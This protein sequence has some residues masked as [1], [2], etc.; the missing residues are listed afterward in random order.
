ME[1]KNLG[2]AINNLRKQRGWT[3]IDLAEKLCCTRGI[4]TAYENGL[5][6]PSVD[7]I[8]SLTKVFGVTIDTLIGQAEIKKASVSKNPKLWRKFEQVQK[9]PQQDTRMV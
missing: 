3:Q 7:K 4:I 9:L 2:H 1:T 6:K 5:K 8:A